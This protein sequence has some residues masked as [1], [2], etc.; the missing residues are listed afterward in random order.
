MDEEISNKKKR[1][2]RQP[3]EIL[4]TP[5]RYLVRSGLGNCSVIETE[6]KPASSALMGT[7]ED[8]RHAEKRLGWQ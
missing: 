1:K 3:S 7:H 6:T 5:R 4:D 2:P 8:Q